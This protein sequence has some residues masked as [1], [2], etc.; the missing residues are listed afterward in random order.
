MTSCSVCG[1]DY[2]SAFTVRTA[3]GS[4]HVFDS[5]ECAAH[6]IAPVCAQCGC[7]ILGHG[8][9]AGGDVYC[10]ASCAGKVGVDGLV[11]RV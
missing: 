5:I 10:C 11:D 9:Q 1:N 2:D 3:D 7:Q 8:V 6:V 4:E